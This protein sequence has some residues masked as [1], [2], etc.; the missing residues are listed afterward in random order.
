[1]RESLKHFFIA[2]GTWMAFSWASS[3]L[4]TQLLPEA[5]GLATMASYVL[6]FLCILIYGLIFQVGEFLELIKELLLLPL[7]LFRRRKEAVEMEEAEPNTHKQELFVI[8]LCVVIYGIAGFLLSLMHETGSWVTI[9]LL[10]GLAWGG[11][12]YAFFKSGIM[13]FEEI[14]RSNDEF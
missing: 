1:M 14:L 2:T 4:V 12:N 9:H 13:T 7:R 11:I 10:L 3:L 6:P 8:P 5:T